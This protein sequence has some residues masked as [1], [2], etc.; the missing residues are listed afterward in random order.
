M[1]KDRIKTAKEIAE[2]KVKN[3]KKEDNKKEDTKPA[4]DSKKEPK[5]ENKT[6][7]KTGPETVDMPP[8]NFLSFIMML[9]MT[10]MQ[11]LGKIANPTTGK[12]E[13]DLLQA[14]QTITLLEIL[15]EKTKGNLTKEEESYLKSSVTNLRLNYVEEVEDK[16]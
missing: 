11:Q 6:E 15:E 4:E 8:L 12:I 16:S 2:E 13:K 10:G 3:M 14:K 7:T 5:T 9:S 1:S